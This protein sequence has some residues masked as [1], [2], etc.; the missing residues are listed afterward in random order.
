MKFREKF[1]V[2]CIDDGKENEYK[3]LLG[4]SA[5]TVERRSYIRTSETAIT[6][7]VG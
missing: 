5:V 4:T 2:I 7:L 1:I 6:Q 3:A